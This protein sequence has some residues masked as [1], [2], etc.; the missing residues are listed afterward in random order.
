[1]KKDIEF[2]GGPRDGDKMAVV[3]GFFGVLEVFI[4][5]PLKVVRE[6]PGAPVQGINGYIAKYDVRGNRGR[7]MGWR[8]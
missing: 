3:S 1:M 4:R 2:V 8:H 7:Y 5:L 6:D